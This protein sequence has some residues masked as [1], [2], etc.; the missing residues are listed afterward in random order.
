M[1]LAQD[2]SNVENT[3]ISSDELNEQKKKR[4]R[5]KAKKVMS[6]SSSED[7]LFEENKENKMTQSKIL[8][9]FPDIQHF[10]PTHKPRLTCIENFNNKPEQITTNKMNKTYGKQLCIISNH[11]ISKLMCL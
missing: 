5:V 1:T 11:I 6:S 3:E 2:T 4:R 10:V 7:V 8:P 9:A